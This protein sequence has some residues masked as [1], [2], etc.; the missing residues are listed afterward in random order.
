MRAPDDAADNAQ[1]EIDFEEDSDLETESGELV[2]MID[3]AEMDVETDG[4]AESDC[5]QDSDDVVE[6]VELAMTEHI[7]DEEP[8]ATESSK[9]VPVESDF[10]EKDDSQHGGGEHDCEAPTVHNSSEKEQ[11]GGRWLRG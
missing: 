6:S 1:A 9:H 5:K 2:T 8:P 3:D 10:E 7:E 11:L 4:T